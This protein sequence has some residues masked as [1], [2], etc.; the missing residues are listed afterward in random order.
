MFALSLAKVSEDYNLAVLYP[1]VAKQW[2]PTKN[3]NVGP[4]SVA[5]GSGKKFWWECSECGNEWLAIVGN[6]TRL[7][8]GCS[9]CGQ[10]KS[11]ESSRRPE[12]GRS[13]LDTFP[14]LCK[15]WHPEKNA[16]LSPFEVLP[17]S[18]KKAWWICDKKHE[19][20]AAIYSRKRNGCPYCSGRFTT[21]E[22]NLAVVNP[23][24]AKEWHPIKN[25]G[26]TPYDVLP[27][28]A[29]MVWWECDNNHE[30]QQSIN[31][32]S[33]RPRCPHC[34]GRT[35]SKYNNLKLHNPGLASEWHPT[36]N[37]G[38]SPENFTRGSGKKV[39]WSCDRGHEWKAQIN[40]R[41]RGRGCPK[42]RYLN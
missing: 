2:H 21:P 35:A 4:E 9:V 38:L 34:T 24:L 29:K 26:L 42:C 5:P 8:A 31:Q 12:R 7:G 1:K 13:L 11:T 32:R 10:K 6:R 37:N 36:K 25:E 23:E 41:S 30:W 3:G 33:N 27:S 15:E 20:K 17:A 40:G 28:V 14:E 39:W 19:W 18:G 22:N 16:N